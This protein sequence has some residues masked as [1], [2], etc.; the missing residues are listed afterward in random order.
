MMRLTLGLLACASLA[1]GCAAEQAKHE[2]EGD[3]EQIS[4]WLPGHYDNRAQIAEDRRAGRTP[5]E[6]LTLSVMQ[7]HAGELGVRMFYLQE[8][9]SGT[10]QIKLQRLISMGVAKDRIVSSLWSFTDPPRWREGDSTPELFSGL[11]PQDVTLMHGC[12]LE[13]KKDKDDKDNKDN[14]DKEEEDVPFTASNELGNCDPN[15]SSAGILQHV[16]MRARLDAD[17]FALSMHEV[18]SHGNALEPSPG[19]PYIRFRRSG[20]S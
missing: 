12:S 6:A 17:E 10:R 5:H 8:M 14:K 9:A 13:W 20:G 3:L 19:D 1:A 16:Q 2:R 4:E 7:V 15:V 18:D 11:Q